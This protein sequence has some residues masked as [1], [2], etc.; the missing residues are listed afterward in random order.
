MTRLIKKKC[1]ELVDQV[2]S[3]EG[4]CPRDGV[5]GWWWRSARAFHHLS[6]IALA[7]VSSQ[8][9]PICTIPTL[10]SMTNTNNYGLV[11]LPQPKLP[12]ERSIQYDQVEIKND[13]GGDKG[14]TI[15][16]CT[17]VIYVIVI[18]NHCLTYWRDIRS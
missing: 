6:S 7:L 9:S 16:D 13:M 12:C 18:S 10:N 14:I 11:W 1:G 4:V 5:R 8:P 15:F 2:R 17:T 3:R